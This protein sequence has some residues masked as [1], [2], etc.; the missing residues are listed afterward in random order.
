VKNSTDPVQKGVLRSPWNGIR[1]GWQIVAIAA[2]TVGIAL[3]VGIK[4]KWIGG[5][6]IIWR[7]NLERAHGIHEARQW[8]EKVHDMNFLRR[9]SDGDGVSDSGIPMTNSQRWT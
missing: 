7:G 5:R 2:R 8:T 3:K 9:N 1:I 6:A 4:G